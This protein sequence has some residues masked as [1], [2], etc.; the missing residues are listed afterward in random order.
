MLAF[1]ESIFWEPNLNIA[2][3]HCQLASK[4]CED[5]EI[6]FDQFEYR[7]KASSLLNPRELFYLW[8]DICRHYDRGEIGRQ[9][10]DEMR[11]LICPTLESLAALRRLIDGN[12]KSNIASS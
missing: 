8:E 12:A 9:E 3:L 4:K 2:V 6:M 11:S 7:R 1:Q 10:L 5:I